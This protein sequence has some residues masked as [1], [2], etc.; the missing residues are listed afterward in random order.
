MNK[1]SEKKIENGLARH[2]VSC[3]YKVKKQFVFTQKR[4]DIVAKSDKEIWAIEV[5]IQDWKGALRQANLNK[6]GFKYSYVAIWH[7]YA[8]RALN[9]MALF[10]SMGIGL[11]TVQSDY[12]AI[13]EFSPRREVA[14]SSIAYS[15]ILKQI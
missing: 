1:I 12:S 4:I 7:E 3:N 15:D 2:L 14:T 6:V 5:K 9:N 10:E 8:H 13:V 11:I